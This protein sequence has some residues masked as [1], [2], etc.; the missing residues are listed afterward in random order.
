MTTTRSNAEVKNEWSVTPKPL[1]A[2]VACK[3]KFY[4]F[5]VSNCFQSEQTA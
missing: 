1:Y 5:T 2:F 3:G 4:V